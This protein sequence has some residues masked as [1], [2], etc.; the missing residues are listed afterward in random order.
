MKN[1][2]YILFVMLP[3][4]LGVL[5]SPFLTDL[6]WLNFVYFLIGWVFIGGLG[7]NVGLHRWASHKSIKL[8]FIATPVVTF[9]SIIA[10]QGQPIWWA[11]LH[12]GIHHRHTDTE[13]D[14]HS[15][16]HGR[17]H[18]FIGWIFKHDPD[19]VNYKYSADLMRES[20]IV[21]TH[22]Y[23]EIIIWTTWILAAFISVDLLIYMFML[24]A[25]IGLHTEGFV[26]TVCH[27]TL[28]YRNFETKD[29][30]RNVPLIGYL[31]WGNGWHNNHHAKPGNY[32]FGSGV[33]NKWWEVDP[34][35]IFIPFIK[36]YE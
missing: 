31:G 22:K 32:D 35:K 2:R 23:Y 14:E 36:R 12:R 6:S 7:I 13:V 25:V 27:S 18:S 30:S 26:N 16:I 21:R 17:V 34:C 24:P 11:A 3:V 28:G 9:C 5:A 8:N 15:P 29:F 1:Y 10:A 4:H 19:K 33:S 20:W